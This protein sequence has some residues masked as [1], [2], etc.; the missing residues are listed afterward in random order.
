MP[1]KLQGKVLAIHPSGDVVTDLD[2]GRLAPARKAG[3][4]AR[5]ECDE[6]ETFGIFDSLDGMPEMTLVAFLDEEQRL[7]LTLVGDSV[8]DMLRLRPGMTVTVTWP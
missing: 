1:A 4:A 8:S 7:R 5:I 6:H 3:P 2:A